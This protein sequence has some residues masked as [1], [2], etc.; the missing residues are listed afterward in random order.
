VDQLLA[1]RH[2]TRVAS[3]LSFS[4]AAR[5]FDTTQSNV[6]RSIRQLEDHLGAQLLKRTTRRMSLTSEGAEYLEHAVRII[7]SVEQANATVGKRAHGLSGPLR[8]FAPVSLGR[9]HIVPRLSYFLQKHPDLEIDLILDDWP[10]DLIREGIDVAIRVGPIADS[11]DRARLLGHAALA[12]VCSPRWAKGRALGS[13]ADLA[14]FSSVIFA[15]PITLNKVRFA[16]RKNQYEV[17]LRGAFRTNSSEAILA[18]AI[19]GL[20]FA[21]APAWLVTQALRSRQLQQLFADWTIGRPLPIYAVFPNNR[22]P[23][24]RV[25]A[26]I[27]FLATDLRSESVLTA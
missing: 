23:T 21:I 25:V 13:P 19:A 4:A 16:R 17:A 7:D 24:T 14:L 1:L 8:I 3:L 22:T 15:G 27:N 11:T 26:F 20:G 9:Q 2:F 18:A 6:S 10:Q 12:A 5:E